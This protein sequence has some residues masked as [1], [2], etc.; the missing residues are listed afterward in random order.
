[1]ES[2]VT[3]LRLDKIGYRIDNKTILDNINF[4]LQP[5]EFKLITGPSGC[6]KSTLLS[7]FPLYSHPPAV[8]SS[9]KIKIM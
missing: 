2:T 7:L 3:L 6:G 5:S 4:Q 1:M 9:L 8:T